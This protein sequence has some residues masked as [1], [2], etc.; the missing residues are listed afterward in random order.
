MLK[1]MTVYLNWPKR[2]ANAV[3]Y[4]L[5]FCIRRRLKAAI[6]SSLV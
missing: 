3:F 2:D 5:P 4:S 6:I 1:G